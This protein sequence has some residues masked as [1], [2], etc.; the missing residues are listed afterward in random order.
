MGNSFWLG[1]RTTQNETAGE[2]RNLNGTAALIG[3][4]RC[5]KRTQIWKLGTEN[6]KVWGGLSKGSTF[7]EN[8]QLG[9]HVERHELEDD[10]WDDCHVVDIVHDRIK[11]SRFATSSRRLMAS[12]RHY[13]WGSYTS[14]AGK[15]Q[16]LWLQVLWRTSPRR[17]AARRRSK[18]DKLVH[19]FKCKAAPR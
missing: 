8:N 5:G 10:G 4:R 11:H 16:I 13:T 1:N 18:R 6:R 19:K 3:R 7:V 9:W 15:G 12:I 17:L 2:E 14:K